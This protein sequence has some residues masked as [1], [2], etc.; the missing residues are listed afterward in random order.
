VVGALVSLPSTRSRTARF[1]S[2]QVYNQFGSRV[3]REMAREVAI[4]ASLNF[5]EA[6][7][8]VIPGL[9]PSAAR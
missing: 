9:Q 8:F 5:L 3:L 4:R 7:D 1:T 2:V 6:G